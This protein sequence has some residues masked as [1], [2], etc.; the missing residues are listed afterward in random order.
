MKTRVI[1]SIVGLL[2]VVPVL[3][4]SH[5]YL[6]CLFAQLL[7]V[8]SVY[9]LTG[10]VGVRK[11]WHMTLPLYLPAA[12]LPL[13]IFFEKTREMFGIEI[14]VDWRDPQERSVNNEQTSKNKSDGTT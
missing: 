6:G 1:T 10:A 14:S 8:F 7:C 12:G 5:T 11:K 2:I 4:F 13:L 9:E 3:V